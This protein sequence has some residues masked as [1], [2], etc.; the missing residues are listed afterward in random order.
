[1]SVNQISVFLEN[2]PGQLLEFTKL[3]EAN[4]IDLRALSVAEAEDFGI[5]RVIVDDSLKTLSLLKEEGYVCSVTPVLA[6]EIPDQPGALV[7][8]LT[9]LGE[10]G[11]NLEY[12][13]AFLGRKKDSAYMIFRV[14]DNDYA[15]N[16]L[17]QVGIHTI[18][19]DDL[20][21]LFA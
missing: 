20:H 4:R 21:E 7:S 12:M 17:Q 19:Q 15:V 1:M 13:Y 18:G 8:I 5:L 6:V 9:I 3:L 16:V 11:V 2:T 14:A 10:A